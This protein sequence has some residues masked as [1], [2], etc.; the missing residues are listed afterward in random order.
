MAGRAQ[1]EGL[2]AGRKLRWAWRLLGVFWALSLTAGAGLLGALAWLG[3][4]EATAQSPAMSAEAVRPPVASPIAQPGAALLEASAD[5]ASGQLPRIGPD[6]TPPMRAYAAHF[7]VTDQRPRVA[8]LVAGIGTNLA[9]SAAAVTGLPP[10]VS[11][12]VSPYAS[13][14]APVLAEARAAGHELL[15]SLPLEPQSYPLNDPGHHA[16]LTGAS[17]ARNAQLLDWALTRFTGYVGATGALGELRGERFAAA[18][19]QMERVFDT[20]AQRGLL[21]VDP[22]PNARRIAGPQNAAVA[23]RGVDLV[24]D[25]PGGQEAV[26]AALA[27]LDDGSYGY[28]EETGE[29]ISL[30]RLDARPIATLSIEAQER[31]ERRERVYRDD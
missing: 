14:L 1:D 15:V 13:R 6:G 9:E 5:I 23:Y 4:P 26:D 8:L 11:L 25:D 3:A 12:A 16:L 7:D 20:L 19:E 28:C 18:G 29:P 27:R 22:R 10:A 24:V 21:Y 2:R 30:K 17:L 31:H